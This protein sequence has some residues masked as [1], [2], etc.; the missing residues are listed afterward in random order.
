VDIDVE[1]ES[2]QTIAAVLKA[3]GAEPMASP[4]GEIGDGEGPVKYMVGNKSVDPASL[5]DG[6]ETFAGDSYRIPLYTA[7]L[8]L[9]TALENDGQFINADAIKARMDETSKALDDNPRWS[10]ASKTAIKANLRAA[11]D[12]LRDYEVSNAA[13]VENVTRARQNLDAAY[14]EI[15]VELENNPALIGDSESMAS[16]MGSPLDGM[17]QV[18][19]EMSDAEEVAMAKADAGEY[20]SMT[21]SELIYALGLSYNTDLTDAEMIARMKR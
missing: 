10:E 18:Q 8:T 4:A 1:N 15:G 19:P 6:I 7:A 14:R 2:P 9:D 20:E 13:P 16:P 3:T 5:A 21:R 17:G 12:E 11:W